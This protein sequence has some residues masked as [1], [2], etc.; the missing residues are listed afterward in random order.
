LKKK[1]SAAPGKK[2]EEEEKLPCFP[3]FLFENN[4]ENK[5]KEQEEKSYI[6]MFRPPPTPPPSSFFDFFFFFFFFKKKKKT[7][8]R[9]FLTWRNRGVSLSR[10]ARTCV[11]TGG[12]FRRGRRYCQPVH[13]QIMENRPSFYVFLSL[14]RK[15]KKKKEMKKIRF[16]TRQSTTR[17]TDRKKVYFSLS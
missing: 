2:K 17:I 16:E 1:T 8:K 7:L 14:S 15:K 6:G 12:V 13:H 5:S 4:M 10:Y 11:C 3:W 9:G